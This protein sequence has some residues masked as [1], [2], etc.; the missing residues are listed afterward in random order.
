[1]KLKFKG[2][3][4]I[5]AFF[6]LG[7]L[8]MKAQALEPVSWTVS[9]DNSSE[10]EADL[11]YEAKIDE[12]W[13]I[14]ALVVSDDQEAMGP[15][16]TEII[17]NESK[18]LTKVGRLIE[19]K[20]PISSYDKAFEMDLYYHEDVVKFRQTVSFSNTESFALS[21]EIIFMACDDEKCIFPDPIKFEI[22]ID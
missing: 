11:V 9:I 10:N 13:H 16:P 20:T 22:I 18:D 7:I 1:M 5:I 15:F 3:I 14:Y 12:G 4:L 6:S 21:G 19:E 2:I 8:Q 17:L